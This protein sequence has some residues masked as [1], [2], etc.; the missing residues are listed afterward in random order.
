VLN[1]ISPLPHILVKKTTKKQQAAVLT[2]SKFITNK[3][4]LKEAKAERK[5]LKWNNGRSPQTSSRALA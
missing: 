2:S 5:K 4:E 1:I 3:Q